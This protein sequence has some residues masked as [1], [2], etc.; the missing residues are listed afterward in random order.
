MNKKDIE[1]RFCKYFT[2]KT[3][4]VGRHDTA[5]T[6]SVAVLTSRSFKV[7]NFHVI[8][9]PMCDFLLVIN[10]NLNH[11][12]HRYRNTATYSFKH[13]IQNCDQTAA[14]GHIVTIDSL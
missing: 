10:G 7:N 14:D 8:Q 3:P 6:V 4:W 13:A 2:I 9:K 5:Y 12:S 11:I 1:C